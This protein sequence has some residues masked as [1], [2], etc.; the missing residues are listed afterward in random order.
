MKIFRNGPWRNCL[1]TLVVCFQ[2]KRPDQHLDLPGLA[3]E[4]FNK[5]QIDAVFVNCATNEWYQYHDLP[6][7]LSTLRVFASAWRRTITYGSSMGG[8]AAIRFAAIVGA[9]SSIAVGPQYSPRSL[10]VPGE[11]R[12]DALVAQ[13]EFLYE[14]SYRASSGVDNY[15]I[16]DPLLKID[17]RHVMEYRKDANLL[18]IPIP[19]G[20]HTPTVVLSECG[21]LTEFILDLTKGTFCASRFRTSFRQARAS[22]DEYWKELMDRL[23]ERD[24]PETARRLAISSKFE[25]N[26]PFR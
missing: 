3:E 19:C 18:P 6:K 12:F 25:K 26:R 16:Y 5:L 10:I 24:R 2:Y 23:L 4:F 13:T 21:L 11:N 20:G 7:G 14:D 9:K 15:V 17:E 1:D 8:Y 22:S